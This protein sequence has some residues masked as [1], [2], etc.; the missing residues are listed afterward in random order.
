MK[1]TAGGD[2]RI[3]RAFGHKSA[4]P[5]VWESLVRLIK[6]HVLDD[7]ALGGVLAAVSEM[8]HPRDASTLIDLVSD[9]SLGA[10]RLFLVSNLM[11]SKRPE[12]RATLL[13]L[14]D[15][16][17]LTKEITARLHRSRA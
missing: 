7:S 8:A 5:I 13:R 6:D 9:R 1:L 14:Q 12:A 17:E 4:R 3:G 11:R 15:A 16:P 10:S 2:G